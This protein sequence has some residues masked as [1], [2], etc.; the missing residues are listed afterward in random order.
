MTIIKKSIL[1]LHWD[2]ILLV[3]EESW[4]D[5]WDLVKSNKCVYREEDLLWLTCRGCLGMKYCPLWRLSCTD[6]S[7]NLPWYNV[8]SQNLPLSIDKYHEI[9]S[10]FLS[11]MV[12]YSWY[13]QFYFHLILFF[14]KILLW[15]FQFFSPHSLHWKRYFSFNCQVYVQ[16]MSRVGLLNLRWL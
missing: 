3:S 10:K 15:D 7:H 5:N 2:N 14:L 4:E 12:N 16:T 11:S 6:G 1:N 13:F 9:A 8:A